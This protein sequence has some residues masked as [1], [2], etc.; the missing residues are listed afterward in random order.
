M[1]IG[2]VFEPGAIDHPPTAP[3]ESFDRARIR[4]KIA[5]ANMAEMEEARIKGLHVEKLR[6]DLGVFEV[7]RS[8]RDGVTN[9]S[10]RLAAEVA[11]LTTP[12]ECEVVIYKELRH[13]LTSLIHQ[14]ST[15]IA[16]P[17]VPV[18]DVTAHE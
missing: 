11:T 1:G 8:F 12:G 9:S 5:L 6:V 4:E 3:D 7:V 15:K 17:V 13:L 2:T 18:D 10:R 16:T 14:L